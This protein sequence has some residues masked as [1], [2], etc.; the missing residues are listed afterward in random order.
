VSIANTGGW[1]VDTV[2]PMPLHG[3]AVVLLDEHLAGVLLEMYT[4]HGNDND[5]RV[6]VQAI[7]G[8]GADEF[9][10]SVEQIIADN[11]EPWKAFSA[12]V[13][14]AVRARER[15][16]ALILERTEVRV[17]DLIASPTPSTTTPA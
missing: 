13:A 5:Y 3:A 1:V 10:A 7:P 14:K 16:L 8:P 2:E 15:D 9:A 6:R 17:S 4:Q 12:T 11:P